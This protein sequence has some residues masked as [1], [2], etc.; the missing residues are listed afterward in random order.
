MYEFV[1]NSL[2]DFKLIEDLRLLIKFGSDGYYYD[3]F[4][5]NGR[6]QRFNKI[7]ELISCEYKIL[8]FD[9]QLDKNTVL[10]KNIYLFKKSIGTD[11]IIYDN[12]ICTMRLLPK[13]KLEY[14]VKY[15]EKILQEDNSKPA[16]KIKINIREPTQFVNERLGTYSI[17]IENSTIV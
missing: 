1:I 9:K 13:D 17:D 14:L 7:I 6:T 3:T 2:D 4:F 10:V 5:E 16:V 15:F 11:E 8:N 12:R